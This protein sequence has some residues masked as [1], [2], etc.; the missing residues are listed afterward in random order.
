LANGPVPR[1]QIIEA[2]WPDTEGGKG[3]S[4]LHTTVHRVRRTLFSD[5]LERRGDLWSVATSVKI[6]TDDREF[7]SMAARLRVRTS[8][9]LTP[10]D[11]ETAKAAVRLYGGPYLPTL[12]VSWSDNRRRR[13]EGQYLR[14]LRALIDN[15]RDDKRYDEAIGYAELYLQTDADDE[16]IHEALMRSHALQGNRSAALRHYHRYAQQIRDELAAQPSR[17]LRLLSEQIARES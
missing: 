3:Q 13:L 9:D 2:L 4:A 15:A 6:W 11:V 17:R 5:C 14:L 8:T 1:D 12:D 16:V 7:E 10:E